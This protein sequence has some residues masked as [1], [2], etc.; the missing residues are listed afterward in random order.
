MKDPIIEEL[1][2]IRA[3]H[4]AE[5]NHDLHAMIKDLQ[6]SEALSR[7]RGVKFVSPP[8]KR[9]KTRARSKVAS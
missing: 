2:R 9:K 6:R 7:A 8:P 4:A 5:F 3:E 1:H